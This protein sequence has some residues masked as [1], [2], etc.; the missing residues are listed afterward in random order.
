MSA[1]F[2]CGYDWCVFVVEQARARMRHIRIGHQNDEAVEI[3]SGL[4]DG[5]RVVKHPPNELA[6]GV[7]VSVQS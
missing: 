2:R 5:D 6:D 4:K 1:I 7:R 3:R